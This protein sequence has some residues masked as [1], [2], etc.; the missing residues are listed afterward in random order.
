[1][2][3]Q[4]CKYNNSHHFKILKFLQLSEVLTQMQQWYGSALPL[5]SCYLLE[6]RKQ[7]SSAEF[8][9]EAM[10]DRKFRKY[11]IVA[12]T[13]PATGTPQSREHKKKPLAGYCFKC[14]LHQFPTHHHCLTLFSFILKRDLCSCS[15][16]FETL[17]QSLVMVPQTNNNQ[18][19]VFSHHWRLKHLAP[20]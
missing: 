18:Q 2:L 17:V 5:Q 12:S 13:S 6:D 7:S 15:I 8:H 4:L 19:P 1:M 9:A 16:F 11:C 3:H 14:G 20:H 10:Q